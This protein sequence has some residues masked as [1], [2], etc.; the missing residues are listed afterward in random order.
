MLWRFFSVQ[1]LKNGSLLHRIKEEGTIQL[2]FFFFWFAVSSWSMHLSSFFTFPTG[3]KCQTTIEWLTLSSLATSWVV[4]GG[5]VSIML[6]VGRCQLLIAG[7]YTPHLQGSHLLCKTSWTTTALYINEQFLGQMCCW[8]CELS[9][10]L[11]PVLNANKKKSLEFAFCLTL[12]QCSKI[13][14]K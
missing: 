14:I 6:S 10:A 2:F 8:C 5:S 3:F 9:A 1:L 7:H 4:V 13:H 12:F 11:Q